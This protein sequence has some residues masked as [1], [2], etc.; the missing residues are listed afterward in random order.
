M[1]L[2]RQQQTTNQVQNPTIEEQFLRILLGQ[3]DVYHNVAPEQQLDPSL[4]LEMEVMGRIRY[5]MT[6]LMPA[7]RLKT[8]LVR[9]G[10]LL[11]QN[12][13]LTIVGTARRKQLELIRQSQHRKTMQSSW[14]YLVSL[15]FGPYC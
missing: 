10:S 8:N 3:V 9:A 5:N 6:R 1:H 13:S 2:R 11:S 15:C 7:A 4:D 14:L 12:V